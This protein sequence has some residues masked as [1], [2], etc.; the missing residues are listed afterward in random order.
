MLRQRFVDS[1][2]IGISGSSYGGYTTCM[3]LTYG[4]DYFTHGVA[5][6][7]VTD[8]RLYDAVYTERY[9]DKPEENPQGYE[10]ASV[11]TQAHKYKENFY[12]SMDPWTTMAHFRI[13]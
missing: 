9:M 3:A 4:A 10:S 12:S 5:S 8:W 6:L 2:R 7:S 11:L 1:T 13:H